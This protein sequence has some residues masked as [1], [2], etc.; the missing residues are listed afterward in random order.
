[1]H[2]VKNNPSTIHI[3][4]A[5]ISRSGNDHL[6]Q[7][8]SADAVVIRIKDNGSGIPEE[9]QSRLFDPFFTTKPMG[10]GTGIGLA[11]S[12]QIT[13]EKHQGTLQCIS[14]PGQGTEFVIE[15]PLHS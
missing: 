8:T 5:I 9:I 1:M 2:S 15:I 6:D 4:T 14:Q 13:V 11:I 7:A 3:S 12:Y 10:Q